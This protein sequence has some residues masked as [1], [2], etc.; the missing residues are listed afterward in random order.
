MLAKQLNMSAEFV[1]FLSAEVVDFVFTCM[2]NLAKFW[3]IMEHN[4]SNMRQIESIGRDNE[5]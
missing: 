3:E 1:L 4:E 5:I 2:Y